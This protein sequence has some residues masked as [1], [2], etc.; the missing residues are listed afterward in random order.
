MGYGRK[1]VM[2]QI[3]GL[4][5]YRFQDKDFGCVIGRGWP[6]RPIPS[7]L[8]SQNHYLKSYISFLLLSQNHYHKGY[9]L[10]KN[11]ESLCPII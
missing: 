3:Q 9:R 11:I 7:L 1:I 5:V 10:L 8:P 2:A 4:T 6:K